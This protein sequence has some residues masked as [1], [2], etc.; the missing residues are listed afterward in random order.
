MDNVIFKDP[1]KPRIRSKRHMYVEPASSVSSIRECTNEEHSHTTSVGHSESISLEGQHPEISIHEMWRSSLHHGQGDGPVSGDS[2]LH[3]DFSLAQ[4]DDD[5][6]AE[7]F[8]D[9]L[10]SLFSGIPPYLEPSR[11][12]VSDENLDGC[13]KNDTSQS[14]ETRD[15]FV[16]TSLSDDF[17]RSGTPRP[18]TDVD[19][20]DLTT[21]SKWRSAKADRATVFAA[22]L[23]DLT[24][25]NPGRGG[26]SFSSSFS[27]SRANYLQ[28]FTCERDTN[29][30]R[31]WTTVDI[32]AAW[33]AC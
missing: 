15:D 5:G 9:D 22:M 11:T 13:A 19:A 31:S 8:D 1:S 24:S 12:S 25:Q 29:P 14:T 32:S 10:G 28:R 33:R 30:R 20:I 16:S 2:S 18:W 17:A 4:N 6:L 27:P 3:D 21:Q 7:G 23:L 26:D